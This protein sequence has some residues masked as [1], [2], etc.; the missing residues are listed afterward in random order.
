MEKDMNEVIWRPVLPRL[1]CLWA[2]QPRFSVCSSML[3]TGT[4]L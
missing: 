1:A 3:G 2:G 4:A